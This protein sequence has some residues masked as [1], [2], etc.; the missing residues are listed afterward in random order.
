MVRSPTRSRWTVLAL[1]SVESFCRCPALALAT[2]TGLSV[3]AC[4]PTIARRGGTEPMRVRLREATPR[5]LV[6]LPPLRRA[7]R[8]IPA[9]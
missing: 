4:C 1:A 6:H 3:A 9:T 5:E 7:R 8:A 2:S